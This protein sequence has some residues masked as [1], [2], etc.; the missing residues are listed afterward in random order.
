MR[1]RPFSISIL[2]IL[3]LSF[4]F[5]Q[6]LALCDIIGWIWVEIERISKWLLFWW[7]LWSIGV[8][9]NIYFIFT[10]LSFFSEWTKGWAI[11]MPS[12]LLFLLQFL[13]IVTCVPVSGLLIIFTSLK[14]GVPFINPCLLSLLLHQHFVLFVNEALKFSLLQ[15]TN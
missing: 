5:I 6:G 2:Q 14:Q 11:G 12:L 4:V 1:N 3:L 7:V 13:M 8:I 10:I 9:N 15:V